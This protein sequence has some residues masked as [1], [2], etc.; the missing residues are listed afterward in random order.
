MHVR[1]V[2]TRQ[3]Q[4]AAQVEHLGAGPD[5]LADLAVRSYR[6]DAASQARHRLRARLCVVDRPYLAV[7]Q[8]QAGGGLRARHTKT[9]QEQ[10]TSRNPPVIRT[11]SD[12]TWRAAN[13]GR[14]RLLRR[15]SV[16]GLPHKTTRHFWRRHKLSL[17]QRTLYK[18]GIVGSLCSAAWFESSYPSCRSRQCR[19]V[20][21]PLQTYSSPTAS[22]V[23]V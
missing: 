12:C 19:T 5:P 2:E 20:R 17:L 11:F 9:G 18:R 15:P 10:H 7:Q 3:H 14:S 8:H 21:F 22:A 1:I 13:L 23:F 6:D 4:L 16:C